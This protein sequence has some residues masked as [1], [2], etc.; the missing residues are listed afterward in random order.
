MES[1]DDILKKHGADKDMNHHGY[2]R[3]YAK[4]FEP[5]RY[6]PITLLE[7][8]VQYGCSIKAWLEYFTQGQI[9]GVDCLRQDDI[10]DPRF[11]F[12]RCDQADP[13][14]K[15]CVR[16]NINI[17]IDDGSHIPTDQ[18]MSFKSLW[19]KLV[20]G[21]VYIIEDTHPNHDARHDWMYRWGASELLWHIAGA[22]NWH[23][24]NYYGRPFPCDDLTPYEQGFESCTITRGLLVIR[25]SP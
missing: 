9:I 1:L 10:S 11:T 22:I 14:L 8:G 19:P 20:R 15:N 12:L 7:I 24:K 4:L 6:K 25:K 21:G 5:L 18:M 3:H 13:E 16:D 23:G 2:S 17:V